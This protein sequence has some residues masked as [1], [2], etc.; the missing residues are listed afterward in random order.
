MKIKS[1]KPHV[2]WLPSFEITAGCLEPKSNQVLTIPEYTKPISRAQLIV[3]GNNLRGRPVFLN[4][5][6]IRFVNNA[7]VHDSFHVNETLFGGPSALCA[8]GWGKI[9]CKGPVLAY[10]KGGTACYPPRLMDIDLTAYRDTIDYLA[11]STENSS[12][13]EEPG[14]RTDIGKRIIAQR[15]GKAKG[16][17]INYVHD[18][19]ERNFR[20]FEQVEVPKTHPLFG[21]ESGTP[22]EI[23]Q[24]LNEHW[25]C[26]TY[27]MPKG[28]GPAESNN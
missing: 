28:L 7:I 10:L 13:I 3:C 20:N 1:Y 11:Y 14:L 15:S 17:R 12:M 24:S 16:V 27:K 9:L 2:I 18:A 21:M 5:L 26:Y 25:S 23:V 8:D 4:T 19:G 6:F 22:L